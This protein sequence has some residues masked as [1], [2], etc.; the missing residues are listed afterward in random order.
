M[1]DSLCLEPLR[2]KSLSYVLDEFHYVAQSPLALELPTCLVKEL[3]ASD[4]LS[5]Y[6]EALV[7]RWLIRW[8][9]AKDSRTDDFVTT[10]LPLIRFPLIPDIPKVTTNP[11]PTK[12]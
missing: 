10:L 5:N 11:T 8:L 6:D 2:T 12:I 9:Q 7:L 4:Q 3:L 1:A